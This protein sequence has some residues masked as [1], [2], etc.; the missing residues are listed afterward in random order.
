MMRFRFW[1]CGKLNL[2]LLMKRIIVALVVA[3][4]VCTSLYGQKKYGV[5]KYSVNF[6]RTY[7]DYESGLETQAL[8]GTPVEILG[9]QGYWLQIRTP[10]AVCG[11]GY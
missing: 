7:P 5:V 3:M 4:V 10:G 2:H 1:G 11:L 6:M 9:S 8:M